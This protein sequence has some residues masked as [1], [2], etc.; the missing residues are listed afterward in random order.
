MY[1]VIYNFLV[2]FLIIELPE[3]VQTLK[4]IFSLKYA[5]LGLRIINFINDV[6]QRSLL[7]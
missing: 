1:P 2:H 4:H 7:V 5:S 3:P 6:T